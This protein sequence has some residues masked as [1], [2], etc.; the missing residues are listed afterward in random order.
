VQTP[1]QFL[2]PKR[3]KRLLKKASQAYRK[4]NRL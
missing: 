3:E 2:K 1:L 4:L